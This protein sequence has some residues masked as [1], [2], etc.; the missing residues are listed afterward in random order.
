VAEALDEHGATALVLPVDTLRADR[1]ELAIRLSDQLV[2]VSPAGVLSLLAVDESPRPD[3][4][5][6]PAGLAASIALVQAMGDAGLTAP[7]WCLTQGAVS[8][9][10]TDPLPNPVQAQTWGMGRVAALEHSERWGGLIDLPAD[11]DRHAPARLAALL[12]PGRPEDQTAIRA[13]ATFARRL[14]RAPAIS[15]NGAAVWRP[16][17]TTLVTGGTGGLGA[18]VARWLAGN[19]APHLL[20]TSRSG[21]GAPGADELTRELTELG[22]AVTVAACDVSDRSALEDLLGTVPAE[23]PLTAVI[24]AAGIAE[25][26]AFADLDLPHVDEVLRPKAH[27]ATHLHELTRD[28]DLSA[29]V[30]FSSGAGAWGSGLQASYAAANTY[31]DAL[32]EHRRTLGLPAT[33]IAWGPWGDTG[34]ATDDTAVAYFGRRGLTPLDPGLAVKSLHHALSHGDTTITVADID[35]AKFSAA[36]T[37]QRPSPLLTDLAETVREDPGHQAPAV[38]EHPLRQQLAAGTPAE[39]RA[40]LLRHVQTH[41]AAVLGHA[42]PGTVPPAQPFQELGFDSLT[43]VE[44]RN[45]LNATTGLS[46]PPTLIFD[47]P[48]PGALADLLGR[49]LIDTDVM[50]EG[51]VLS[52][53]DQWDSACEPAAM[54]EAARRRV[55]QRLELL[56]AKW[57]D[58]GDGGQSAAHRD[59]EA[60]TADDIFDL[61]SDEFGKS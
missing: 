9:S 42:D 47:H 59:L 17:G 29:F 37:T 8:V 25:N 57:S 1:D 34:M 49:H 50:S 11:L 58:A 48:S 44:L 4:P 51:R 5:V 46:L 45:Q 20:L 27:A 35:W 40:I 61:I 21:P 6:V 15:A 23:H 56:L 52:D 19:G 55:T 16:E 22:S 36:F 43:A 28:L 10:P 3:H 14:Q 53:L 26:A 38:D 13:T 30:M 18:R 12:A 32:A 39:R 60:A 41:V 24:H 2:D 7:L 31:L 54:D 33:S